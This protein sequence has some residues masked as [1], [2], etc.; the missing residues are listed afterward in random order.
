MST[1]ADRSI[2]P[3]AAEGGR[4]SISI[5]DRLDAAE[6]DWRA[7]LEVA[8]VSPYQTYEMQA[9]WFETI[10]RARALEPFIIVKRDAANRAVALLPFMIA[11]RGPW[12]V[13]RFIGNK[14]TNFNLG[15]FADQTYGRN[16]ARRLLIDAARR[17]PKPPDLYY[18]CNMPRRFDGVDSPLAFDDAGDSASFGYGVTLPRHVD[19][20][21][22]RFSKDA[23]KKLRKKEARLSE[24][25]AL[26]YEHRPSGRRAR[27]VLDALIAQKSARLAESGVAPLAQQPG[28]RAFLER[29]TDAGS[30]EL[31]ALTLDDRIIAVYAGFA[32]KDRFSAMLNSFDMD[33]QVARSSP[34]DLLLHALMRNLVERGLARFDL[35]AGEARYK[36]AVCDETIALCDAVVPVNAKGA[37]IAPL[38]ARAPGFKRRIKQSP[39]LLQAL[40]RLRRLGP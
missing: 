19:E 36:Q 23:R 40:A 21:A 30:L 8:A 28:M 16:A 33:E 2:E 24:M 7:L 35:G 34:G 27:A 14:E 11:R 32:R 17:A 6:N 5:F 4:A 29:A 25:G 9:A 37:I 38:L 12:R 18:L 15:L 39:V 13:A 1:E 31:H 22:S 20:L 3:G 26:F 10:G